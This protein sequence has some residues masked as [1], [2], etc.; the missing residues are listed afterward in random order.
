MKTKEIEQLQKDAKQLEETINTVITDGNGEFER[1]SPEQIDNLTDEQYEDYMEE[2][3]AHEREEA[4]TRTGGGKHP[5]PVHDISKHLLRFSLLHPRKQIRT[6]KLW[7]IGQSYKDA[8]K[9]TKPIAQTTVNKYLNKALKDSTRGGK[10]FIGQFLEREVNKGLN[11]MANDYYH[12]QLEVNSNDLIL[13]KGDTYN[14]ETSAINERR[15]VKFYVKR[16]S[17][18]DKNTVWGFEWDNEVSVIKGKDFMQIW[19]ENNGVPK[20]FFE[21]L[22]EETKKL[23]NTK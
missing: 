20:S 1:L 8:S 23:Y 3:E 2:L 16:S 22:G 4:N 11:K 10:V 9:I 7:R 5:K 17:K 6:S 19:L 21:D 12:S 18:A 13:F 14:D 15:Y